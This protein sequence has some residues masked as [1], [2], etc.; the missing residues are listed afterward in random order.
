MRARV[1]TAA[2]D[3]SYEAFPEGAYDGQ[4]ASATLRDPNGDGSWL[5]LKL[6]L[7]SIVPK[8]GTSDPG[9]ERFSGDITIE[10]DG[11]N[12]FDVED[13]GNG[14][15]DFRIRKSGALLAGL[16]EGLGL[17][18]RENGQVDV[19]LREVADSLIDGQFEGETV[20]FEIGN[21][22]PKEGPTRDQY[23]AFGH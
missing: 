19:D 9:R 13:F 2:I 11:V 21:W 1:P 17:V 18:T 12:V 20:G 5:I 7:D 4:I 3:N 15:L 6:G 16:A 22:Q 10:T 8:E 14:K 23:R